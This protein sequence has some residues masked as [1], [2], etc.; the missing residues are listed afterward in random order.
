M[1][2]C[3][4]VTEVNTTHT[5]S[6]TVVA[7]SQRGAAVR[8]VDLSRQRQLDRVGARPLERVHQALGTVAAARDHHR[9]TGQRTFGAGG[10]GRGRRA[11]GRHRSHDDDGGR[12]EVHVGQT[13]QRRARHRWDAVVPVR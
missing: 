2:R 1:K 8:R 7:A 4:A 11:E 12:P 13:G 10:V 6:R 3:T 5:L 9:A